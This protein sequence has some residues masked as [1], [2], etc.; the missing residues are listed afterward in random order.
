M[1]VKKAQTEQAI[2]AAAQELFYQRGFDGVTMRA[3]ATA[4]GITPGNLYVYFR[5]KHDLYFAVFIRKN[6][7]RLEWIFGEMDKGATA[8]ERVEAYAR[9]YL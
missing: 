8:R 5:G 7:E 9:A 1:Q 2:L 6:Q 3:V 4:A